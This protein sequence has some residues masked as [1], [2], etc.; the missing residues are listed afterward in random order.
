[1]GWR[2]SAVLAL[3]LSAADSFAADPPGRIAGEVTIVKVAVGSQVTGADVALVYLED[4][5]A[6]GPLPTGP[7]VIS[8]HD[9]AF[10]PSLLV[11]PVGASVEFP[12]RDTFFHN[13]FST[14]NGNSFDLGLYKNGDSKS[15]VFSKP[16]WV[17]IFCNIH[18]QM[19]SYILV[20]TNGFVAHPSEDGR[21]AFADV[22]PGTYHIAAWFPYGGIERR[23]VRV[24]PG[25]TTDV[26]LVLRER[27][28]AG[29]HP[30]KDGKPYWR[31]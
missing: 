20:V 5:P 10:D 14:A 17:P 2:S 4:A 26:N 1:L 9:K 8:Q 21:F 30:N 15:V 18:P 3:C 31:Y 24:E 25:A 22:P 11:V 13:V 23:E 7:F 27:S 6:V 16:G 12:N 28:G 19:L 29:R